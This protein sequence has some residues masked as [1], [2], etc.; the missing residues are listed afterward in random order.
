MR[1]PKPPG[2]LTWAGWAISAALV[3]AAV[4]GLVWLL[5]S[6]AREAATAAKAKADGAF[7][8]GRTES[9]KDAADRTADFTERAA[10][11]RTRT[12]ETID[13]IDDACPGPDCDRVTYDGLCD[14]PSYRDAAFC[15]QRTG[16]PEPAKGDAGRRPA[17]AR[18]R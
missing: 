15:L 4:W 2:P 7:A 3:L 16:R 13:A 14:S 12:E 10:E 18:V 9:A 17:P 11:T 5:G 1:L 6:P 8:E